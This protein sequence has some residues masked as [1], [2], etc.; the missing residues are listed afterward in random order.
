MGAE[1]RVLG[2]GWIR[3]VARAAGAREATVFLGVAELESGRAAGRAGAVSGGR[4]R[5]GLVPALLALVRRAGR[6]DDPLRWTTL[7]TRDLA[8]ELTAQGHRVSADT[9]HKL[10]RAQGFS[11]QG[12]AKTIQGKQHPDRDGQF[13]YINEQA[14]AFADAGD[15]V[16]SVDA[17]KKEQVGE[18]ANAG[19]HVAAQ[20]ATRSEVRDH[21]FPDEDKSARRSRT[22][23]MTWAANYR[24]RE[25]GHRPWTPPRSRSS[26]SA[27]GG[28]PAPHGTTRP[29]GGC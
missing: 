15:P 1:A 25:R 27:A 20:G 12:N 22:G 4:G 28:A 13:G 3:L 19:R 21:D 10:L 18:Y 11:L 8:G 7:S 16:I 5:S 26:R 2:H 17:K 29:R 14:R 24:V 6:S 23:S 9:V